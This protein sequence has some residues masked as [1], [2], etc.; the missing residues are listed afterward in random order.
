MSDLSDQEQ[1]ATV[2][3]A[4]DEEWYSPKRKESE[5]RPASVSAQSCNSTRRILPREKVSLSFIELTRLLLGLQKLKFLDRV[6]VIYR[7]VLVLAV[8]E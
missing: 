8:G 3:D 1:L 2:Y 7:A 5:E 6:G 4:D